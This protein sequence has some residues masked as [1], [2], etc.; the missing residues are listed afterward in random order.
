[1]RQEFRGVGEINRKS[2]G[3][4]VHDRVLAKDC[5]ET[6][7]K[8]WS[9]MGDTDPRHMTRASTTVPVYHAL[10]KRE[11]AADHDERSLS[12]SR[13]W[14]A[15]RRCPLVAAFGAGEKMVPL[16]PAL[17]RG[18]APSPEVARCRR[19]GGILIR[20]RRRGGDQGAVQPHFTKIAC[21]SADRRKAMNS[22]ASARAWVRRVMAM[23][24]GR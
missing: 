15:M 1:M 21:P 7:A 11:P 9:W 14:T 22:C 5:D 4:S 6:L 18:V 13:S 20:G 8:R 17:R 24:Q 19:P 2:R 23:L 16:R 3:R 12:A 10:P